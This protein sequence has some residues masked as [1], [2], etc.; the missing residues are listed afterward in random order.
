MAL[1]R[2][3]ER[4]ARV[5]EQLFGGEIAGWRPFEDRPRDVGGE[6]AE[7]HDTGEVGSG[8]LLVPSDVAEMGTFA[9]DQLL[10]RSAA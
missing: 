5:V 7:P 9:P 4:Q 6:I 8:Q 10:G 2:P 1:L 3:G